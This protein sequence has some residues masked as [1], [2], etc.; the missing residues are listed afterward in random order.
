MQEERDCLW[1][2]L[3]EHERREEAEIASYRQDNEF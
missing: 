2:D 1:D 3:Q